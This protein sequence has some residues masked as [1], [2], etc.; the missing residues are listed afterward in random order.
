MTASQRM[1]A[2]VIAVADA[3]PLKYLQAALN[4]ARDFANWANA[5][6]YETT[7]VTDADEPVT[8][9]RLKTE[10]E[11]IL[12]SATTKPIERLIVY[13]AGHGL[14]QEAEQSLWLVSDWNRE[15]RCISVPLLKRRLFT[16]DVGQVAFF[17]DACRDLPRSYSTADLTLDAVIGY[18]LRSRNPEDPT[19][20]VDTFVASQD[21]G[22]TFALPGPTPDED[23]CIFT[24]VLLPGL[25]G[26]KPAAFSRIQ[27][28]R[29]VSRSLGKFL[30]EEVRDVASKYKLKLV[31][32]IS[33]TFPEEE[34]I[35]YLSGPGAAAPPAFPPWPSPESILQLGADSHTAAPAPV[36]A[37]SVSA[38]SVPIPSRGGPD[39]RAG[40]GDEAKPG[41][42]LLHK[43]LARNRPSFA[44]ILENEALTDFQAPSGFKV[45]GREVDQIWGP[46][47]ISITRGDG[48]DRWSV[49]ASGGGSLA[50]PA[51]MLLAFDDGTFAAMTAL[52]Q[53]VAS[54]V[55]DARGVSALV[56]RRQHESHASVLAAVDVIMRM[57]RGALR[58]SDSIDL[59]VKLREW[60]QADP[61]LGVVSAYLYDSLGDTDNIRRMAAFYVQHGQSI[62]YDIALLGQLQ[63]EVKDGVLW[64][65]VPA[66]RERSPRTDAEKQHSWTHSAT[67]REQGPVGGLWPWM[68]Q[69]WPFLDDPT[70][71]GSSLIHPELPDLVRHLQPGRF[72]TIDEEGAMKLANMFAL[73]ALEQR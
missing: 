41:R 8:V 68:R 2:V 7:V 14:L 47:T 42:E 38:P 26:T 36:S 37:P 53:F 52:P 6:G 55:C 70:D 66:V 61:V 1:V 15:A 39:L 60:K 48:P 44:A 32:T 24:G 20:P 10:L 5:Q 18:G 35:Y 50:Q 21:Y 54:L 11:K 19:P 64:A 40:I 73:I 28:D 3:R 72:A 25:W 4:G 62:P 16:Y 58:S 49:S 9:P 31:P 65:N 33:P 45:Y 23:I 59:A 13:F 63:G 30:E 27:K 51:P 56:Y 22:A 29:V 57:E 46:P 17:S 34:D 69:G 67:P 12:H 43:K 71:H